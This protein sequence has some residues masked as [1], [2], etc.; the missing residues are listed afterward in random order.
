MKSLIGGAVL[1]K[2][3]GLM[4]QSM[5]VS[6]LVALGAMPAGA[7]E[8]LVANQ[9]AYG[10]AVR[11]AQPGDTVVLKNGEW[12]DFQILFEGAGQAGRLITLT[13]QSKGRV[14]IT[15]K[16]N[17]RL[18]GAHLVVSGLVFR[19]GYTPTDEVISFRRDSERLASHA[20]V[21]EV[22]IDRFNPAARSRQDHWVS[23]HGQSN[24]VDHS[25]FVGKTNAGVTLAVIRQDGEP[26][27]NRHRIDHN[28]FGF[29]PPLGS[30]GGETIRIGTSEASL[31][32]SNTTVE[33][34][35]FEHCDGEVEI[36]SNKSGGNVFRGNTFFESQGSLVLRHGNG[37]LVEGN[38]FLGN[39]KPHT[40]GVRVIN[41]Q[42]TVRGNYMEGVA[43]TGFA[44]ALAVMNGVPNSAINRYHQVNAAL[45]ENN[46]LIDVA[47]L[48]LGAGADAE[49][50][51]APTNSRFERNLIVNRGG[52]DAFAVETDIDGI[53]F[54]ANRQS[55]LA[56]ASLTKGFVRQAIE[57]SR[58]ENGLLY[59]TDP[60]LAQVGAPRGLRP[61][62]KTET[63][64]DWYEKPARS[65]AEFSSGKTHRVTVASGA[66]LTEALA[67]AAAGDTI[68]LAAG[69]YSMDAPLVI[70]RATRIN[71]AAGAATTLHFSQRSLFLLRQG[72]ALRLQDLKV[73]GAK[74][75][76]TPGNVAIA[77]DGAPTHYS[78]EIVDSEFTQFNSSRDFSVIVVGPQSFAQRVEI[79]D[80]VFTGVSGA[81]IGV[82]ARNEDDPSYAIERAVI[83][84]SRFVDVTRVADVFRGGRDES[85]F[86]PRFTMMNCVVLR[87]PS[88]VRLSGV[89][90]TQI[91]SNQF[92]DSGPLEIAHGVGSP[93]TLVTDNTFANTAAPVVREL[94]AKGLPRAVLTGNV[95]GKAQ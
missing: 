47:R 63:G 76:A 67:N 93:T 72:G 74:A 75:P 52:E 43:G 73:S 78:I 26:L 51:A 45:I 38:V 17:L 68:Q 50:S 7:K 15:G 82:E 2:V 4:G 29:R 77:L 33:R 86:G 39:G 36:V 6:A 37:N 27:D 83:S 11:R 12:R 8:Y 34:N 13:A 81:V 61:V 44:S 54:S 42:Q 21:T 3:R 62:T 19:D 70:E 92:S 10:E 40:G 65:G 91:S 87:S 79:R 71:G 66:A 94:Y 46:T 58:D 49:R 22:V 5:L 14:F 59:P 88:A 80:S 56:K 69:E 64:V 20:R 53:A 32:A 23:L 48:T 60:A 30:N 41:A 89:L 18:A 55:Q 95:M 9:A 25:Q 16:S 35:Y 24:R 90:F 57:L 1:E 84:G 31:S 85:T 28:Y